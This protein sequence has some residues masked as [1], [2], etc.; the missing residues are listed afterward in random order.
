MPS[1]WTDP[2]T[3]EPFPLWSR[4]DWGARRPRGVHRLSSTLHGVFVHHLVT[5]TDNAPAQLRGAQAFHMDVRGWL[6]IGYSFAVGMAGEYEGTIFELRGLG[7][8]GGHTE[9]MNSHSHAVVLVGD[10]RRDDLTPRVRRAVMATVRLIEARYGPQRVRCHGDIV[11]TVC[12]GTHARAWVHGGLPV[13]PWAPEP[14]IPPSRE[15]DAV[16]DIIIEGRKDH[17]DYMSGWIVSGLTKRWLA[18]PGYVEIYEQAAKDDARRA[19]AEGTPRRFFFHG[20]QTHGSEWIAT[21]DHAI[22]VG[23][24]PPAPVPAPEPA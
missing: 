7:V 8:Q 16:Y 3:G 5:G 11:A 18:S 24:L 15:D 4:A 13:D 17:P 2:V 1:T 14:L 19:K 6:D 9:N 22:P 12:P 23:P 10:T 21:L 20:F